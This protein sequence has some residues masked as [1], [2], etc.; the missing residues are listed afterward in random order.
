MTGPLNSTSDCKEASLTEKNQEPS[1]E[2]ELRDLKIANDTQEPL[3]ISKEVRKEQTNGVQSTLPAVPTGEYALNDDEL[4]YNLL[5]LLQEKL[6][7][8]AKLNR[9]FSNVIRL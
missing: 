8:Q 9:L 3:E 6:L 5:N 2:T 7:F 4:I 1:I